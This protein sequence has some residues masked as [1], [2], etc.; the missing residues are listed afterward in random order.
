MGFSEIFKDLKILIRSLKNLF[1]V[2]FI[3]LLKS[4]E[5]NNIRIFEGEKYSAALTTTNQLVIWNN[6]THNTLYFKAKNHS[7][8]SSK[9]VSDIT[10]I[11]DKSISPSGPI[12]STPSGV[13]SLYSPPSY[14]ATPDPTPDPYSIAGALAL[15]GNI[16]DFSGGISQ[17]FQNLLIID[18][19]IEY[20]E[21]G[22]Y[23]SSIS[24]GTVI[25]NL[26]ALSKSNELYKF[27]IV[28][29][30]VY[31]GT[32]QFPNK[33]TLENGEHLQVGKTF[34]KLLVVKDRALALDS[35]GRIY[36]ISKNIQKISQAYTNISFKT[37]TMTDNHFV[38]VSENDTLI[39]WGY[40]NEG[41]I[42][43][44]GELLKNNVKE[45]FSG[46][47][48]SVI[49]YKS[50]LFEVKGNDK[51]GQIS[52]AYKVMNDYIFDPVSKSSSAGSRMAIPPKIVNIAV[53]DNLCFAL[54]NEGQNGSI[55]VWGNDK[56]FYEN[57]IPKIVSESEILALYPGRK[58]I[59]CL[60]KRKFNDE[61]SYSIIS[62]GVSINKEKFVT[63][64]SYS[65]SDVYI[66]D[67]FFGKSFINQTPQFDIKFEKYGFSSN[68]LEELLSSEANRD[69]FIFRGEMTKGNTIFNII[70]DEKNTPIR[71]HITPKS[72]KPNN[73]IWYLDDPIDGKDYILKKIRYPPELLKEFNFYNSLRDEVLNQIILYSLRNVGICGKLKYVL[74]DNYED[75]VGYIIQ[76]RFDATFDDFMIFMKK[77]LTLVPDIKIRYIAEKNIFRY[78][79]ELCKKLKSLENSGL[80]FNHR[81]L[82]IEN[83]MLKTPEYDTNGNITNIKDIY[84]I[85][86]GISC[87]DLVSYKTGFDSGKFSKTKCYKESRDLSFL[88]LWLFYLNKDKYY[89]TDLFK[90]EIFNIIN[91]NIKVSKDNQ[92]FDENLTDI[93]QIYPYLNKSY[94]YNEKTTVVSLLN[95]LPKIIQN[96][97]ETIA[98]L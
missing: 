20:K 40:C 11:K 63:D 74:L 60:I 96:Y 79:L 50:G 73:F 93:H 26:L 39:A 43:F 16:K 2:N 3:G 13:L 97:E 5:T 51:A 54:L 34:K 4:M 69:T 81:D 46:E 10:L 65:S 30:K 24:N 92:I 6:G 8:V 33:I 72:T 90:Q 32:T 55:K 9:A 29:K 77:S 28:E 31:K 14:M 25:H 80:E 70:I 68:N 35:N 87:I 52:D 88:F 17:N 59:Y 42:D 27:I 71:I 41:N 58:S 62:W 45:I 57:L 67:L 76:E 75:N 36:P 37:L 56:E 66:P 44:S 78:I 18:P 85:D 49:L 23:E 98:G 91:T 21:I 19:P 22:I 61:D 94:I 82:K 64:P 47:N 86:F 84:L 48:V 53:T 95:S 1:S 15:S 12:I 7:I 38:G 83:I 89:P